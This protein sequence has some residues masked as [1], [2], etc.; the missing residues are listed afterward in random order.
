MNGMRAPSTESWWAVDPGVAPHLV[1]RDGIDATRDR[2]WVTVAERG[3][4]ALP[5][6]DPG[7]VRAVD[8]ATGMVV[9][10]RAFLRS[11]RHEV[12]A[13][14][15][16][17]LVATAGPQPGTVVVRDAVTGSP[18]GEPIREKHRT[19]SLTLAVAGG[20]PVVI[21]TGSGVAVRDA[22][23]GAL[24][25]R[26]DRISGRHVV[27]YQ[28]RLLLVAEEKADA[29]RLYDVLTGEPFGHPL[30][31]DFCMSV[32]RLSAVEHDGRLLV[33][34]LDSHADTRVSLWDVTAGVELPAVP[35]VDDVR[36]ISLALV[37]GRP[38]L[39]VGRSGKS[40]ALM[41]WDPIAGRQVLP[42]CF[43]G[44]GGDW[45]DLALAGLDDG[46]FAVTVS[47]GAADLWVWSPVG[48]RRTPLAAGRA[49]RTA[50][51]I[52]DGRPTVAVGG[53]HGDLHLFDVRTGHEFTS[54]F[55]G[56]P[57]GDVIGGTER[58]GRAV[59]LVGGQP[60]RW[61]DGAT[62]VPVARLNRSTDTFAHR[63]AG[64][65]NGRLVVALVAAASLTVWDPESDAVLCEVSLEQLTAGGR[66]PDDVAFTEIDGR[67]AVAVAIDRTVHCWDAGTGEPRGRP[68]RGV[69]TS[70]RVLAAGRIGDRP[71]LAVS[72]KDQ[73]V[74]VFDPA[75][76]AA[77][78]PPMA[79]HSQTV[80]ALAV[81]VAD[82]RTVVVSG[83]WDNTVR[84]WD[85]G[86]GAPV[87]GP[88]SGHDG[89]ITAVR[90][91]EWNG[92][93]VVMSHARDGLPRM[94]R[95]R[96]SGG[97]SGHTGAVRTVAGGRWQGRPVFASGGDDRTVRLWDAA[98][99]RSFGPVLTDHAAVVSHV[100]FAGPE[101]DILVTA[102]DSGVV[103]RWQARDGAP[104]S[105]PL[106]RL[107]SRVSG[108]GT[109]DVDGRTVVGVGTADGVV[110]TWDAVTNE[111]YADLR[112][113]AD[114][115]MGHT[116]LGALDGR[117][118]AVTIADDGVDDGGTLTLWDVIAGRPLREPMTV[119][120]ESASLGKLAMVDGRLVVIQG[121]DALA[122][123]PGHHP[124]DAADVQVIDVATGTVLSRYRQE[125]GWSEHAIVSR[126]AGGTVVLLAAEAGIVVIDPYQGRLAIQESEYTGHR[127]RVSCL[128]AAEVDGRTIVAS[129]DQGND[130][131]FWD[132]DTRDRLR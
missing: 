121:I 89:P 27:T 49:W 47:G 23:T 18:V 20:R 14:G 67:T 33:A 66:Q 50:T 90:V 5:D 36:S 116:D 41:L 55:Y 100:A 1:L 38:L 86:T 122:G 73:R 85:A 32:Y 113:G 96:A 59:V 63:A 22:E 69:G 2:A 61:W 56:G 115:A 21:T 58:A 105:E 52:I 132:L 81:G 109:A 92:E 77:V 11:E 106:A 7:P 3:M 4:P 15:G 88:W 10:D 103:L 28:D 130:V 8:L 62:G 30:P 110:R 19:R 74:H 98:T 26:P 118:V 119:P 102:D 64:E 37:D 76:G 68:Y 97:P 9:P 48:M 123:G 104:R 46:F 16:G 13:L 124:E 44:P 93:P 78:V 51:G 57:V 80:T 131:H 120:E 94:W 60:M 40:G 108:M 43:A 95:L 126:S 75:T 31:C 70:S 12:L 24:I 128:A 83:S 111:P 125:R 117:L 65:L 82:H 127:A 25:G 87:G 79:G 34:F 71:V 84:V 17:R 29:L 42:D 53:S 39:L 99:G 107:A 91:T 6:G 101:R 45:T 35:P 129:G 114:A 72:G 112:I 54:P